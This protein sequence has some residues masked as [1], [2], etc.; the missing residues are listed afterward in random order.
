ML[1]VNGMRNGDADGRKR[2]RG[3]S[4]RQRKSYLKSEGVQSLPTPGEK[5]IRAETCRRR[6]Q[7]GVTCEGGKKLLCLFNASLR[8]SSKKRK[9]VGWENELYHERRGGGF[10]ISLLEKG[11]HSLPGALKVAREKRGGG[12]SREEEKKKIP[13][14][15]GEE[16]P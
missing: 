6:P 1:G 9:C 16:S 2:Q 4:R 10:H 3:K 7:E 13:L 14:F 8:R 12:S 5:G 15:L 11:H